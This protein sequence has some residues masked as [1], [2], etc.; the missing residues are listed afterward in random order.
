MERVECIVAGAGVI[1]L[2]IAR[3]LSLR[4]HEVL[5]VEREARFGSQT[6]ARNSEVIHAGLHSGDDSLK[7]RLC[8]EGRGLLYDFLE[9]R[10]LPHR[11]CGKLVVATRPSDEAALEVLLRRAT[12]RGVPVTLLDGRQARRIEPNL[13]CTAALLSPLSGILDS[14]AYMAA[15]LAEAEAAGAT[16]AT[17]T[18]VLGAGVVPDGLRVRLADT[19]TGEAVT[20][21]CRVLVNA[22]GHGAAALA[23]RIDGL[24]A[25]MM[26]K[27]HLAK[28]SYFGCAG[29]AAFGRLIYPVPEPGGLGIHL[30]LDL[31]GAMR[32]GPDVEWVTMPD[33]AVDPAR[34]ATFATAIRR[35]WPDLP[36]GALQPGFAG[37]RPK[38]AACGQAEADFRIDTEATHGIAGLVQL[39]GI[40]SPGLTASLAIARHVADAC[41]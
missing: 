3:A 8:V 33:A 25:S 24:P 5:V 4:G 23:A 1:G 21:A 7:A 36:E 19:T 16:L 13:T 31:Q 34:A 32:F 35:Y 30:T 39:F 38:L 26:P 20:V 14:Y 9:S 22:A 17:R 11:R 29:P 15:L 12:G 37:F 40:E 10:A 27:V 2:A 28:G 41:A 18:E 6:S